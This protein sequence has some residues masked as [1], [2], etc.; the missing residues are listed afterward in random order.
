MPA[1]VLEKQHQDVQGTLTSVW[2][3]QYSLLTASHSLSSSEGGSC[4]ASLMF[5]LYVSK[6]DV[7]LHETMVREADKGKGM[8]KKT[9]ISFI[10]FFIQND[11]KLWVLGVGLDCVSLM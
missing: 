4:T 7:A 6:H 8:G 2:K 1:Q 5:P 10:F 9:L 3:N 11:R